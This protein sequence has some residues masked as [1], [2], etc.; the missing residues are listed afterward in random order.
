MK[1]CLFD[2][3]LV[4]LCLGRGQ[5]HILTD[6]VGSGGGGWGGGGGGGGG[7]GAEGCMRRLGRG[8]LSE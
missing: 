5:D 3:S 1:V 2:C 8:R 7:C 4:D 6:Q